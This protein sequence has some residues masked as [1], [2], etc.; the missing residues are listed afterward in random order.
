M[1]FV[2][3]DKISVDK[4]TVDGRI[5]IVDKEMFMWVTE[6]GMVVCRYIS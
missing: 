1:Y 3:V 4:K 6:M 5:D 2:Y